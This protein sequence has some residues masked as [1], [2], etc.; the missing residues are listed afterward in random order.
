[1]GEEIKTGSIYTVP[2]PF[3]REAYSSWDED[4]ETTELSW[5]PGVKFESVGPWGETQVRAHGMGSVI[6][7]VIDIHP[8]PRPFPPR[9]FFT[10][11]WVSPDGKTFGKGALRIMT[12]EAFARR[13]EG[14]RFS[15]YDEDL[16]VEDIPP[17]EKQKML[18][19]A[20]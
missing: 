19:G 4:G 5:R 20:A 13:L 10:R 11:K 14:Y 6:Y 12:K 8:L 15:G 7:T 16:V 18:R 3:V 1:M 17:D 9:V 2:C